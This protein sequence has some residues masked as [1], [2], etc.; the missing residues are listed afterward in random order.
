[1]QLIE[2]AVNEI[3][4]IF[5]IWFIKDVPTLLIFEIKLK[6]FCY[7]KITKSLMPAD[8]DKWSRICFYTAVSALSSFGVMLA[9]WEL[10]VRECFKRIYLTYSEIMIVLLKITTKVSALT[11]VLKSII[12]L[13]VGTVH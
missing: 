3:T 11:R 9:S 2:N 8:K 6:A 1:M 4:G 12:M 7:G 5:Y 10:T 13:Y